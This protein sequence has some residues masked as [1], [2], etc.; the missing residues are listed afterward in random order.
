[1]DP[2][3]LSL[4]DEYTHAP[5]PRATFLN[6]LADLAG[7]R[8]EAE[9][10]LP[11]LENDYSLAATTVAED[12]EVTSGRITYAAD[13]EDVEGFFASSGEDTD[14]E[15]SKRP[16]VVVIHEN[17]GLNA[18]IEDVAR[19]A[20]AAGFLA[21]APDALS[22][23]GGTPPDEDEARK[24][25]GKLDAD[26][27]LQRF[28]AAVD[29]LRDH[30]ASNGRVGCVGFCWGGAMANQLAVHSNHLLAAAPFYGRQAASEDVPKIRASLLLHYAE[31]D[32]RINAGIA[33]Y[34]AALMAAGVDHT[35]HMYEGCHHAFHNDTSP[36]RYD[37]A[38]A[39]LA[40]QRTIDFFNQKLK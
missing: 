2:R 37:A 13:Q 30:E 23:F 31:L 6:H 18:H 28:L 40:W 19:R 35:L 15:P 8:A 9:A 32:E 20:A 24:L 36:T 12:V 7:G 27:T 11:R 5:L 21:L 3:F 17:R 4:Y 10:L 39:Q 38:A 14:G 25:I 33:D 29:Y 26:E 16:G 34:E 1:M 22:P